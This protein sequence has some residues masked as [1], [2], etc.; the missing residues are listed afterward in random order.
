M[1]ASEDATIVVPFVVVYLIY[2]FIC[3][4]VAIV[5]LNALIVAPTIIPVV[6][7]D[8]LAYVPK[9]H[10]MRSNP[11]SPCRFGSSSPRKPCPCS[12]SGSF[13]LVDLGSILR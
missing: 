13:L 12:S 9:M 2:L 10:E 11:R 7:V 1:V 8:A 3:A 5:V 4:V 6:V